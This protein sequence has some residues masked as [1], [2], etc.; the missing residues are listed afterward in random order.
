LS[1]S[2]E[3]SA[4]AYA[5]QSAEAA[6]RRAPRC[7]DRRA[8]RSQPGGRAVVRCGTWRPRWRHIRC[9]GQH[10]RSGGRPHVSG[11]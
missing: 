8:D 6:A 7:S 10:S 3:R 4:G 9:R 5:V 2:S 11:L 1:G